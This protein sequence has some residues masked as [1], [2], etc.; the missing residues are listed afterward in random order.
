ML[1]SFLKALYSLLELIH[2]GFR[3]ARIIAV[4][5]LMRHFTNLVAEQR[6]KVLTALSQYLSGLTFIDVVNFSIAIIFTCCYAYQ[7][8]YIVVGL[9]KKPKPIV[10]KRNHKFA[11]LVAARNERTVISD[12]IGSI[13]NQNYPSDLIDIFVIAD[14]CTD[15]TA[16]IARQAGATVFTRH[17]TEQVGKGYALDFGL[18]AIWQEF[19][20]AEYEAYFVFDADNVLDINYFAEMNKTFDAGYKASTSYRNSKNFD[21]NWISGGY[22]VWFMREAKYLNNSRYILNN[23]CAISGTGFYIAADV[24]KDAGGW[25]WHLLTEDIEFSAMSVSSG[26]KIAYCPGAKLYDEQPTRFSDSWNQRFR[27]AKGFYQVFGHYSGKLAKGIFTSSKGHK[28]SCYDILM[29]IA[30]VALLSMLDLLFNLVIIV[31]CLADVI[32]TGT[33]L[34]SAVSSFIFCLLSYYM[35]TF[36]FGVITTYTEWNLIR[37]STSFKI[38]NLFT[39]PLFMMTYMPIAICALFKK[40]TWKPIAHTISVDVKDYAIES[41]ST[42]K[43]RNNKVAG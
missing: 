27:W 28:F 33:A 21:S 14:N 10:A 31:L 25:P 26:I 43:V 16:A 37:A 2:I 29:N 18:K 39:F 38:R 15:D 35:V 19:P 8:F 7:G 5:E 23:S 1:H 30:P 17:N 3:G 12:L 32:T 34:V 11:V 20:N 6:R 9:L 36:I 40:A 4:A 24:L 13:K 42:R 22:A 41:P